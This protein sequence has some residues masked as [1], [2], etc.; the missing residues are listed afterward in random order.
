MIILKINAMVVL[1]I[2]FVAA[3]A[4]VPSVT[5]QKNHASVYQTVAHIIHSI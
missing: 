2:L 5:G 1:K 3:V 4:L